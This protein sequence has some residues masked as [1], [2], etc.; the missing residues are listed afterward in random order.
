MMLADSAQWCT[1]F[2]D[3]CEY[4]CQGLI[5]I[6]NPVTATRESEE[7]GCVL[8]ASGTAL[9]YDCRPGAGTSL[10]T[11]ATGHQSDSSMPLT[12]KACKSRNL[13]A[14]WRAATA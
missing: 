9:D 3:R 7:N 6:G 11:S 10:I 14:G 2:P 8:L 1:P 13:A 12:E 4:S 5:F